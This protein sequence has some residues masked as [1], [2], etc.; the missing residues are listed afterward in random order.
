MGDGKVLQEEGPACFQSPDGGPSD[1]PLLQE[2]SV[3]T[4]RCCQAG[5]SRAFAGGCDATRGW[6]LGEPS[7]ATPRRG[8]RCPWVAGLLETQEGLLNWALEMAPRAPPEPLR[9]CL[10][11]DFV[12]PWFL[13]LWPSSSPRLFLVLSPGCQVCPGRVKLAPAGQDLGVS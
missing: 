7:A 6:I 10:R 8:R 4:G 11:C 2:G 5:L 12:M 1:V 3:F 13:D 9:L